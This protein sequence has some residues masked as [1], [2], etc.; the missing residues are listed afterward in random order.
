MLPENLISE[1]I[2]YLQTD[3]RVY[4]LLEYNSV[5]HSKGSVVFLSKLQRT[6]RWFL[7]IMRS[8]Y[9]LSDLTPSADLGDYFPRL[10]MVSV[11]V[12]ESGV[13]PSCIAPTLITFILGVKSKCWYVYDCTV[14]LELDMLLG[15]E[16]LVTMEIKRQMEKVNLTNLTHP[17]IGSF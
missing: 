16:L 4:I 11:R 14:F 2:L 7:K 12:G 9:D 8:R 13:D 17:R 10:C 5:A 6:D 3:F 1:N 15:I